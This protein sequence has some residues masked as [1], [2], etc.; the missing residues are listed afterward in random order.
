MLV[1]IFTH[2]SSTLWLD[3][4]FQ[5]SGRGKP[6]GGFSG[7]KKPDLRDWEK[8]H[9][10]PGGDIAVEDC[11]ITNSE[12]FEVKPVSMLSLAVVSLIPQFTLIATECMA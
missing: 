11:V 9:T 4:T 3:L 6:N 2:A 5:L 10:I 1:G 8:N 7:T 12:I